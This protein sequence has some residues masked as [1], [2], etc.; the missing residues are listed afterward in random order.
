M[1]SDPEVDSPGEVRTWKTGHYFHEQLLWRFGVVEI[2]DERNKSRKNKTYR[3][4]SKNENQQ[5]GKMNKMNI[6]ENN[7][8]HEENREK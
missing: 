2:I 1:N 6:N 3:K 7:E 4:N 8:E 5:K